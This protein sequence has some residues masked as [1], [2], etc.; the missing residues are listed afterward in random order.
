MAEQY[1]AGY[2]T[3]PCTICAKPT[4]MLGTKLCDPCW[5]L[6][7]RLEGHATTLL[8][9]PKTAPAARALLEQVLKTKPTKPEAESR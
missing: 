8:R 9:D 7:Q 6:K 1:L 3:V 4:P 5:Q 2:P